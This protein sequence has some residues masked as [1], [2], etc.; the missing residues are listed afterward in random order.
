MV[1]RDHKKTYD[2]VPQSWITDCLKMYKISDEVLKFIE[3][4][5][6]KYRVELTVGVKSSAEMKI[7]RGIFQGDAISP[8]LFVI[9]MMP[10]NHIGNVQADTNFINRK[11]IANT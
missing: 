5:M 7:N 8:L 10:L 1:W 4:T 11:K 9:A 6:K 2:M 3:I